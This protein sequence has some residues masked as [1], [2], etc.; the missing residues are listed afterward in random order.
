MENA[1]YIESYF[2][3]GLS[4]GEKEQFEQK[5]ITD[6]AFAEEVAF[7]CSAWQTAKNELA[8]EKKK[9]FAQIYQQNIAIQKPGVT[10]K[11]WK[12]ATAAAV[13]AALI[14][15]SYLYIK[16]V[17]P[18]QLADQYIQ[19]HLQSLSITMSSQENSIQDGLNLYNEGKL[20]QALQQFEKIIS[21]DTSSFNAKKYAGIVSLQMKQ[22]DKALSYFTQLEN[23]PNLYSNPAKLLKAI[24][25][26]ER[27]STDDA[28]QAK[29]LL[30][31]VM[32]NNL[33]GKETAEQWLKKW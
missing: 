24:T 15:G 26:M 21:A 11:L 30:H 22:Y 19:Q 4:V 27:N 25:L 2:N 23:Y 9:R 33:E 31:Q 1:D 16:P 32:Q 13:V 17:S 20:Q 7:Y 6:A 8:E 29:A 12:Y 14:F 5:I 3:N 10:I 28:E 18:K